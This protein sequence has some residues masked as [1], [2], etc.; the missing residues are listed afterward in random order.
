M[1]L[2]ESYSVRF[3]MSMDFD[4]RIKPFRL[5]ACA[6]RAGN[7]AILTNRR[8]SFGCLAIQTFIRIDSQKFIKKHMKQG[9][10]FFS[11]YLVQHVHAHSIRAPPRAQ[12][13]SKA[14]FPGDEWDATGHVAG[15][16]PPGDF[17][18][19]AGAERMPSTPD[20]GDS[21]D[22]HGT[23]RVP[24]A[25]PPTHANGRPFAMSTRCIAHRK[26][27]RPH[28]AAV[29]V[30]CGAR[31]ISDLRSRPVPRRQQ[32]R[33]AGPARRG[34]SCARRRSSLRPRHPR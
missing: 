29:V 6:H 1:N 9:T 18:A 28:E 3:R 20:D 23:T 2:G 14:T 10:S 24:V 27:R 12:C 31:E 17:S 5:E 11:R 15:R 30:S 16:S 4:R 33:A 8:F 19:D 13:A 7:A 26:R 22:A 34:R 25:I 21:D 32:R